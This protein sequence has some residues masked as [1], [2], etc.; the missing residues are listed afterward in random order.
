MT[1]ITADKNELGQQVLRKFKRMEGQR[2]N[3]ENNWEEVARY[4]IPNKDDI[5]QTRTGGDKRGRRIFTG[6]PI[7]TNEAL[8]SALHG[9][10]TNPATT[11]FGLSSGNRDL[12]SLQSVQEW[13]QDSTERMINVMNQ[14][15]FQPQIHEVFMD[16]GSFGTSLLLIE[17]DNELGVRFLSRPIYMAY[18]DEN[19]KGMVDT[20]AFK[21]QLTARQIIQEFGEDNVNDTITDALNAAE[22]KKFTV[23]HLV[24][25]REDFDPEKKNTTN[26][27]FASIHVVQEDGHVLR[28]SGFNEMPYVVTRW[29]KVS[30]E[31]YGRSPS[32]T[33]M[34]DIRMLNE[35]KKSVIQAAQK[36]INPILQAPDTGVILPIRSAP[37]SI[38]YYRA[39]TKDRI[40]PIVTGSNPGLGEQLIQLVEQDIEKAFFIDQLQ[41]RE[42]D[43]MTATEIIQRRE[44]Q[45]RKLGPVLGRQHFELLKPLVDR[46]FSILA[47][48][49]VFKP[50]PEVIQGRN[51]EVQFVSQIAK[52]QKTAD[53]DD[54]VRVFN[55]IA[56]LA[57][58]KPQMLDNFNGDEIT[59]DTVNKF[60]LN[61]K[62]L[63]DESDVATI[64]QQRQAQIQEQQEL[65][66]AQQEADVVKTATEAN[67]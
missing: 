48:K 4:V 60:G 5:W 11:W 64:R 43:R 56:P 2:V 42:A 49:G 22:E 1:I 7:H 8:A 3:W 33:A 46:V 59:R 58:S 63:L 40:E 50:A 37:G 45:L 6:M 18:I 35:M 55:L 67:V 23:I 17:E 27:P 13:L 51:I 25:P 57:Q 21:R 53:A 14:S 47:K 41:I 15:N 9:M 66:Q 65:N 36:A 39:G 32:M 44:E 31:I 19:N 30:G 34:P 52:A 24:E 16:L 26:K 12:D 61:A 62:Y 10:L 28:E 38:N 54:L 20:V 29:S